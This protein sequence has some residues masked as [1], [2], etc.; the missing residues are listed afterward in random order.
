MWEWLPIS[1]DLYFQA[2][3]N[4]FSQTLKID[5]DVYNCEIIGFDSLII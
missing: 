2:F 1:F 5:L 3:A 4:N